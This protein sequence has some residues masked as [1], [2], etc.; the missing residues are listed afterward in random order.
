MQKESRSE[1]TVIYNSP[2]RGRDV[3][4]NTRSVR[5]KKHIPFIMKTSRV[6]KNLKKDKRQKA[7]KHIGQQLISSEFYSTIFGG[8]R[9]VRR[10]IELEKR[11]NVVRLSG[12]E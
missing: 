6:E 2:F 10:R 5:K 11:V 7:S 1:N 9:A 8:E 3:A 4:E 12:K